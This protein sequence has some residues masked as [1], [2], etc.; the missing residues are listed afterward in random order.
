MALPNF[1]AR[2]RAARIAFILLGLGSAVTSCAGLGSRSTVSAGTSATAATAIASDSTTPVEWAPGPE[3]RAP[4]LDPASTLLQADRDFAV[5]ALQRG[6]SVAFADYSADAVVN[7]PANGPSTE[8]RVALLARL[9]NMGG[10]VL[11]WIPQR[12]QVA[13]SGEMGVTW[14]E[15]SLHEKT[16]QGPVRAR[17][18]YLNVWHRQAD[19]AW[20]AIVDIA[21]TGAAGAA[22]AASPVP[23]DPLAHISLPGPGLRLGAK[24]K[25]SAPL[26]LGGTPE[27]A[28]A[29]RL[30]PRP[31]V[32]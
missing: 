5:D 29:S 2:P 27:D 6:T 32:P 25:F 14:G 23:R 13:A 9:A 10:T 31:P 1:R 7:L 17:G 12:V 16:A 24:L 3:D 20:K 22:V 26:S 4:G 11:T 18:K 8:T 30:C 28:L 21:N 19:G 15:W